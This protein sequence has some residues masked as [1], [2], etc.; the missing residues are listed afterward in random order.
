MQVKVFELSEEKKANKF[1]DS[2]VLPE[3]GAIHVVDDKI[4][5]FYE[6]STEDYESFFID[7]MIDNLKR[8]LFHEKVRKA[9]T[10]AEYEST[11]EEGRTTYPEFDELNKKQREIDQNIAIF[12]A[13]IKGLE[14]WKAKNS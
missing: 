4:V 7:R 14:E 10:D 3:Q 2:V 8:N 1:I 11:K 9:A 6:S 5:V 12:K 13:K